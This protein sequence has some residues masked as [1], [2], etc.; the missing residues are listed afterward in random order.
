MVNYPSE[1]K[2]KKLKD[3]ADY[4]NGKAHEK[5]VVE[6]GKYIIVN[7][8]FI[9]T[10]GEVKKYSDEQIEP[11]FKDEIAIVLSDIPNGRALGKTYLV[12]KNDKYSLNQRIAGITPHND[13]NSY[14]LAKL[15]NRNDYFLSFN[16]G[17]NQTNLSVKNVMNFSAKY[18]TLDEQKA[19]SDTL[20]SFDEH[21]DNLTRLIE[22]KKAIRDGTLEDIMSRKIRI[23]EYEQEWVEVLISKICKI[24]DGTH[25]TPTYTIQGVPFVSV[26]NI[27]DIYGTNKYISDKDYK[28]DFKVF[29]EKGDILMTRIGDIGTSCVVKKDK[30]LAYYVSLALFKNIKINSEFLNYYISSQIFRKELDD[31]TLHH[32]TPK[33]INKGEIGKCKILYPLDINE[34]QAIAELLTAMDDEIISLEKEL[35]KIKQI[36]EGA[37]NDLLTG[38]VRLAI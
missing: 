10:D 25:Q 30:P 3:V 19:I 17:I 1:W 5:N 23:N 38:R 26:E 11:L 6:H 9:S 27:T 16:D 18:P 12:N 8:K 2:E 21:I 14:F 29:P 34:Q 15:M 33:K 20:S 37:M 36:R 32:A 24:Y 4:R 31:R 35:N 13:I 28:K 22:K 7:A